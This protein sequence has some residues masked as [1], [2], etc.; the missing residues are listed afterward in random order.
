MASIEK[1]PNGQWRARHRDGVGKE[2]ASHFR[3]KV[4]G[5]AWLDQVTTA[6]G[7]GTYV[8]PA[9]AKL[10]VDAWCDRWIEGYGTRK[11]GTV[12]SAKVHIMHIK[13]GFAGRKLSDVKPSDVKSWT[14]ALSQNLAP[15]TVYAVYRRL[16]Q[17]MGDAVHGGIIP[18]SPCSRRTSPGP[19]KQRPYVATT[20]QVWA[21]HDAM[22]EHLRSAILLG[23]FV[24]LR[25]AE[26]AALRVSDMDFMRAVVKPAIQ[27]PSEPLKSD[28]SKTPVP[29]PQEL[30]LSCRPPSS[31]GVARRSSLIQSAAHRHPGRSNVRSGRSGRMSRV[32]RRG[33]GTTI[34]ATTSR[35]C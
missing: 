4:D 22:P 29:I 33:S 1:R 2:H 30:A 14:V 10:T 9:T 20:E 31:G 16:A 6:I 11:P 25:V 13:A 15:S 5:Q 21:L 32:C 35:R 18:R 26:A 8:A 19:A 28:A 24:G 17:I 23:A 3:R 27:Y 7:S 12:R 34:F